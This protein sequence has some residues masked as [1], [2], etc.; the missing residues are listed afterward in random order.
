MLL[1]IERFLPPDEV[2]RFR[3]E[4]A[5]ANWIDG[6]SSAGTLAVHVKNNE[7]LDAQSPVARTLANDLLAR[8]GHHPTFVAA[9]M[10]KHIQAPRFNRYRG[11]QG[12][13]LHVD[14][15]IMPLTGSR[16]VMRSD[17]SATLFLSDPAAYDGGELTVETP[18]GAQQVKLPAGDLV[19]YPA[20]SLH[21]VEPVTRGERMAAFFWVQSL[22]PDDTER[23]LL[24]DLD[25]TIQSL[26]RTRPHDDADLLQLT[27]VY[28]NLV[29]RFAEV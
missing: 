2:A 14:G 27:C 1:T 12:Y 8:L 16:D 18:F 15:A 24:F 19:L 3:A 20:S 11:S 13:G 9:T 25:R 26:A 17:V 22:V 5:R 10:P 23:S 7:Q 21:R 28:H 6:R 29:R 4:L